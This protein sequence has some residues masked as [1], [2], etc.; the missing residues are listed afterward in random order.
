MIH[1]TT[2]ASQFLYGR[3]VV[4]AALRCSRRQLYRLYVYGGAN[5]QTRGEDSQIRALA[6]RRGVRVTV[7]A[8]ERGLRLL[9][10]MAD[11]RPHNGF[12]LEASPLPQPPVTALGPLPDDY[13]A[14]P[15]YGVELG[16]QSAEEVAVNGRPATLPARTAAYRPL[17]VVLDRVVDPGNLGAILRTASFLGAAA[18]GITRR[19]SAGL[20]PVALKAS[21]GAAES[22]PL[23]SI[24]S[25]PD[26]VGL[27]RAN[28][29]EVYAAVAGPPARKQRR[30]VDLRDVEEEDPLRRDPCVLLVGNEGEGLDPTLVKRADYEV[31]IPNL[32]APDSGVD[33]LN[34]SV[35]VGLLCSAF[36]KGAAREMQSLGL[37][38]QGG[39]KRPEEKGLW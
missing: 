4:E 8:N 10:R 30:H 25:L 35:A 29:W 5:R 33:S 9:D 17:V 36:L 14:E 16:H 39:G 20:T 22:L 7:L 32:S 19:G 27:S 12:V 31:N 13:A 1:Y 15:R 18:V 11:S 23:F 26:F 34:V 24:G 38:Q 28:G 6:E 3:S 37:G 2:A 21:A